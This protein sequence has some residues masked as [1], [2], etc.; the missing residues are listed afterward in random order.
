MGIYVMTI[1]RIYLY[2]PNANDSTASDLDNVLDE[3]MPLVT[4]FYQIWLLA[5]IYLY[6]CFIRIIMSNIWAS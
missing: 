4:Q 1:Y 2:A 6:E 3:M 5:G